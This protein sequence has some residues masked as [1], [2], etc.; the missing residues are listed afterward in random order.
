MVQQSKICPPD[1][2]YTMNEISATDPYTNIPKGLNDKDLW[3]AMKKRIEEI[4]V[5]RRS[6]K[7]Q[8]NLAT[9][10][11]DKKKLYELKNNSNHLAKERAAIH[12]EMKLVKKRIKKCNREHNGRVS[13]TLAIEFMLIAQ[14]QL[15]KAVF[16]EIRN[17]AAMNIVGYSHS[18][19]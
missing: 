18:F 4:D 9:S 5:I 7:V 10:T 13:E 3:T 1:K 8:L 6:L 11:N 14:E 2:K 12:D 15:P 19:H 17:E 16:T